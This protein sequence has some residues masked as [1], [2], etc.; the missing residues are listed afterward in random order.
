MKQIANSPATYMRMDEVRGALSRTRVKEQEKEA[1]VSM[2]DNEKKEAK[3]EGVD[4]KDSKK[5]G[6]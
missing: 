2:V 1:A 5:D 4:S 6:E 3:K